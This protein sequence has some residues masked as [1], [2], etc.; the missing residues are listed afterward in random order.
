MQALGWISDELADFE[1]EGC[2]QL[3]C[4]A[5]ALLRAFW[6]RSARCTT[7]VMKSISLIGRQMIF[8]KVVLPWGWHKPTFKAMGWRE[9]PRRSRPLTRCQTP[10][11]LGGGLSRPCL[12]PVKH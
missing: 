10:G 8:P 3:G 6:S 11:G 12:D 9:G 5:W 1:F 7:D 4:L 2:L